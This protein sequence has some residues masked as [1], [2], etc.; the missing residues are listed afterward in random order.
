MRRIAPCSLLLLLPTLAFAKPWQGIEPGTSKRAEVVAKFGEPSRVVK[1]DGKETLAYFQ[2]QTIRGTSQ[3]QFRVDL[4]T[5]TV[6]RIDVFPGPQVERETVEATYG[7]LCGSPQA[8]KEPT[9]PCYVKKMTDDFRTYFMYAALGVAVFFD[10][11]GKFVHS[12][13][14]QPVKSSSQSQATSAAKE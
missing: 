3:T 6:E 13:I 2:K 10:D 14:F 5:G 12:F 7:P 4:A 11:Q 9:T 8:V 1:K